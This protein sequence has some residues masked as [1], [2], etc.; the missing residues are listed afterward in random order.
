MQRA[1]RQKAGTVSSSQ[2]RA[3][4][5]QP[6]KATIKSNGHGSI[7]AH[8]IHR[9]I[10]KSQRLN[11]A[12]Q[13]F[14][15]FVDACL[16][17]LGGFIVSGLDLGANLR[18]EVRTHIGN[19]VNQ[20]RQPAGGGNLDHVIDGEGLIGPL[21]GRYLPHRFNRSTTARS[22]NA[23]NAVHVSF[24]IGPSMHPRAGLKVEPSRR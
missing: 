7:R 24:P 8:R 18:D 2:R 13:I 12:K 14:H 16:N 11:P 22:L 1:D 5:T 15:E 10:Y 4:I 9:A 21:G 20:R 6:P 19:L 17:A 23:M 3:D